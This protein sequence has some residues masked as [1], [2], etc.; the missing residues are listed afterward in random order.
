VLALAVT[1]GLLGVLWGRLDTQAL[2]ETLSHAQL[3]WL[4]LAAALGPLQVI[5]GAERWCLAS[6]RVGAPIER[7]EAW[8]EY[9]LSTF[10]NQVLPSGV[11][12]DAARMARQRHHGWKPAL[13]AGLVDRG[14]GQALLVAVTA[15]GLAFWPARPAG[16]LV[17]ALVLLGVFVAA[18]AFAPVR[19]ALA[20]AWLQNALLSGA[21]IVTFLGG[22]ALCSLALGR[23]PGLWL[24]VAIPLVLLA[25]AIPLS[26]GGWGLREASAAALL[27]AFGFTPEEAVAL[28]GC[29]GV[30][31][32]VGALPGACVPLWGRRA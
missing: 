18:L 11:A 8:R 25:M 14:V 6:E 29:Y 3:G 9:A 10:V 24:L 7:F 20:G 28:A 15:L 1:L 32:L 22:F 27:P 21:L 13:L 26:L 12:G 4:A 17:A 5:L 30:T 23:G 19:Q 31:V 2:A 16:S